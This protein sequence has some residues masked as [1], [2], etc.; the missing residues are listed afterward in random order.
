M[1]CHNTA[2]SSDHKTCDCPILKK[3]GMKLVKRTEVDNC[4]AVS[5]I[6]SDAPTPAPVP[7][8]SSNP[9]S[10]SD[11]MA[12]S[13]SLPGGFLASAEVGACNSEE[14]YEYKGKL[15]GAKYLGR[16]KRNNA[17]D[18]YVGTSPSCMHASA[19]SGHS[20]NTSA[21]FSLSGNLAQPDHSSSRTSRNPQGV[22]S[23]YL[24]KTVLNLLQD[25]SAHRQISGSK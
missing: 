14:E 13:G 4:D 23:I 1:F 19:K 15:S 20:N 9:P 10:A 25:P 17:S 8:P 24:P 21:G 12:G 2:C 5:H 11:Q 3:L 6:A 7:A 16:S 22:K 18:F